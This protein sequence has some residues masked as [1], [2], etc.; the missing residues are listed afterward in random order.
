VLYGL[1]TMGKPELDA[2]P[3]NCQEIALNLRKNVF[4]QNIPTQWQRQAGSLLPPLAQIEDFPKPSVRV[5]KL[6]F[7]NDQTGVGLAD[8]HRFEDPIEGYD[9]VFETP[10]I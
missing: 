10:E 7:V 1:G 4:A 3:H 6:A 9:N 8:F 5:S 2:F